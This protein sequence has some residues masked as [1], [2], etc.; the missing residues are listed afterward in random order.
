M[1]ASIFI[2][3]AETSEPHLRGNLSHSCEF[4]HFTWFQ[5]QLTVQSPLI[6]D[7]LTQLFIF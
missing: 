4:S 7:F 5:L 6:I 1:E 3:T 2:Y